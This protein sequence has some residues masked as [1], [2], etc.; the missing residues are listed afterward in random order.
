MEVQIKANVKSELKIGG[1]NGINRG[2]QS[3][4]ALES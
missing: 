1:E 4:V 3:G 2:S